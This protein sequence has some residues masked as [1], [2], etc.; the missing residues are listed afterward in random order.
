MSQIDQKRGVSTCVGLV[1]QLH[2][3]YPRLLTRFLDIL[4][5]RSSLEALAF[6]QDTL[7]E[8]TDPFDVEEQRDL[9]VLF[10]SLLRQTE[11]T[12]GSVD[13]GESEPGHLL[14]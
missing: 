4:Y 2:H 13:Q 8:V 6:L 3:L 11:P 5:S 12:V 1:T 10:T 14:Y 9:K 7:S